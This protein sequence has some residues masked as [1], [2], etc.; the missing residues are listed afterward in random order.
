MSLS[1]IKDRLDRWLKNNYGSK[2]GFVYDYYC[3]VQNLFNTFK[4]YDHQ[5]L[6]AV[7]R[8]VFICKGNVCRSAYAEAFAKTLNLNTISCGIDANDSASANKKAIAT[9]KLRN[10]DL[11]RHKT[12]PIL[13]VDFKKNDLLVVME[14][15]Q[16]NAV[17]K[18][19]KDKYPVA[20]LGLWCSPKRP[21]IHDPYSSSMEYFEAC[22]NHIEK[23]VYVIRNKIDR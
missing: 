14:P 13:K 6:S 7:E 17:I 23:A 15:Y 22:F 9:A 19:L 11:D 10:I 5:D 12:T 8:V 20:L 1:G 16:A 18:L 21:Y 3:R 4:K 2:R